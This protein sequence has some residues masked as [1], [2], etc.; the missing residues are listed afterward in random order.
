MS[1]GRDGSGSR[2]IHQLRLLYLCRMPQAVGGGVPGAIRTRGLLT[3]AVV[4]SLRA[5]M[6]KMIGDRP[7]A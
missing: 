1:V 4:P 3:V 5:R 7:P 2:C 6:P